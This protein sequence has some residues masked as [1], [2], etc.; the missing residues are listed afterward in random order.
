M[1]SFA[2]DD[3]AL[4]AAVTKQMKVKGLTSVSAF[5]VMDRDRG[6][7]VSAAEL[8]N[9]A[10]T[11]GIAMSPD[12]AR[13]LV[14]SMGGGKARGGGFDFKTFSA[15]VKHYQQL[16]ARSRR[17]TTTRQ[18][19]SAVRKSAQGEFGGVQGGPSM[20]AVG[21]SVFLKTMT[22][23][24]TLPTHAELVRLWASQDVNA[25]GLLSL[26]EIDRV[27]QQR[28]PD[29]NHKPALMRAYKFA[30]ADGSG[31]I[32]K[33]EFCLLLRSIYF[34]NDLWHKF[35][36]VDTSH[37]RRLDLGE[38]I[39]GAAILDLDLSEDEAR[40]VFDEIDENG[41]GVILFNEFC[42]YVCRMKAEELDQAQ[43]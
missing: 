35:E 5:R 25:N 27:V 37:D 32:S 21:K 7:S 26:A 11:A 4:W 10:K 15:V 19:T 8:Y 33:R 31:L 18:A 6:G 13:R 3:A 38:F 43:V 20:S 14:K 22:T 30:D 39:R 36:I 29:Y 41:G 23:K 2:D 9:W 17:G 12:E 28:F 34:F 16:E 1:A 42:A 24:Y 40:A